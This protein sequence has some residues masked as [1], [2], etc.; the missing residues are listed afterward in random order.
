MQKDSQDPLKELSKAILERDIKRKM[1]AKLRNASYEPWKNPLVT[2]KDTPFGNFAAPKKKS[3]FDFSKPP[4]EHLPEAGSINVCRLHSFS[5]S[6]SRQGQ[7]GC[8]VRSQND[9]VHSQTVFET[10]RATRHA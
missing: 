9:T 8:G 7:A 2:V 5:A 6:E 1:K 10:Y 4:P 3:D